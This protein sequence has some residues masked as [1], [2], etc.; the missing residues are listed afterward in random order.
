MMRR[1]LPPYCNYER[2]RHGTVYVR[3]RR[4]GISRYFKS[5]PGTPEF[6]AEYAGFLSGL[7]TDIEGIGR[8]RTRPGSIKALVALYY[9]SPTFRGLAESTRTTYRGILNRFVGKHHDKQ[10]RTLERRHVRT[11]IGSMADRPQAANNLLSVLRLIL[12]L[13]C[14]IDMVPVNVARGVK[15]YPTKTKGFH[16]WT[17]EEIARFMAHHPEGS[18]ARL[19]VMLL[20]YTGQ[21]RGDVVRIGWQHIRKGRLCITQSKTGEVV[22]IPVHPELL[23]ELRCAPRDNLTLLVTKHGKPFT[24]AGFGNWFRDRCNE[25]GLKHCSSHGLRKALS[26]RLAESDRTPHQ[27]QAVTGH[28]TLKEVERYTREANRADLADKAIGALKGTK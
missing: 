27:I 5:T 1:K 15:G 12:D 16:T 22:D 9:A 18:R 19:A 13:A 6:N 7:K 17:E 3:F 20:L 21:R 11:I 24:P 8:E 14:D 2:N 28:T 23:A 26:R 25:A 4:R 10:V